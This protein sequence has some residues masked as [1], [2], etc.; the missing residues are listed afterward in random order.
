MLLSNGEW[1]VR[2]VG[3]DFKAC[4]H[5]CDYGHF[6]FIKNVM[7]ISR[8]GSEAVALA[9]VTNGDCEVGLCEVGYYG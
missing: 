9:M 2:F 5:F 8:A 3:F 1:R 7:P 6:V 4:T